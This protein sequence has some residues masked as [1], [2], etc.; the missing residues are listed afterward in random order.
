MVAHTVHLL[1]LLLLVGTAVSHSTPMGRPHGICTALSAVQL[2]QP[3][4]LDGVIS[5]SR[6]CTPCEQQ[7][8]ISKIN[9]TFS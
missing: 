5:L 6:K 8:G 1:G 4:F 7:A 3:P 9:S 2:Q